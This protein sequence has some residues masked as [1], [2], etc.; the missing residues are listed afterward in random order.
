ML[1]YN[2]AFK[3]ASL[4]AKIIAYGKKNGGG[5]VEN[6]WKRKRVKKI[7]FCLLEEQQG[8]QIELP[9]DLVKVQEFQNPGEGSRQFQAILTSSIGTHYEYVR[10]LHSTWRPANDCANAR[11]LFKSHVLELDHRLPFIFYYSFIKCL[12]SF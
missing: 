9:V 5:S 8:V 10:L 12:H 11:R 7:L 3:I 4:T 6:M 1:T 2:P